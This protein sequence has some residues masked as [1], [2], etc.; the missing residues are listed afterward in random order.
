[1][2]DGAGSQHEHGGECQSCPICLFL[3]TL[4]DSRPEVHRH[5]TAA[6]RELALALHAA[7]SGSEPGPQSA[8]LRR[9]DLE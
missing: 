5:L 6:G 8:H 4:H 9:I 2:V 7:L 3:Q 1:M